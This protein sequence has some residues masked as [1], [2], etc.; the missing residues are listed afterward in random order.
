MSVA[1]SYAEM[2]PAA[3][4]EEIALDSAPSINPAL[5]GALSSDGRLKITRQKL[6]LRARLFMYHLGNSSPARATRRFFGRNMHA[7]IIH[8]DRARTRE[9]RCP[10]S[11]PR[12]LRRGVFTTL[13]VHHGQPFSAE[14]WAR[15]SSTRGVRVPLRPLDQAVG[16]LSQFDQIDEVSTG[17]RAR[18][19]RAG[20]RRV[21]RDSEAAES[22]P[23]G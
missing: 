15:L 17:A 8:P 14:H 20:A 9:A 2:S 23:T 6:K 21:E 11:R 22:K 16:P 3:E 7:R 13:A 12:A 1:G 18:Y 4:N 10:R 5:K 19:C